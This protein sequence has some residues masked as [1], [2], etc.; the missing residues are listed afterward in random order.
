MMTFKEAI[1]R[2]GKCIEEVM[3][4]LDRLERDG[5]DTP[6]ALAIIDKMLLVIAKTEDEFKKAIKEAEEATK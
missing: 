3:S 2:H 1:A 6:E 5:K 4:I